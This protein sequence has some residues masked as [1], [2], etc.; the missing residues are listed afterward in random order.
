MTTYDAGEK[1]N[2]KPMSVDEMCATIAEATAALAER[3]A[4]IA[5]LRQVVIDL[6]L[7]GWNFG[8]DSDHEKLKAADTLIHH[9]LGALWLV[10][11]DEDELGYGKQRIA[12]DALIRAKQAGY[13]P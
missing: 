5:R 7:R 13:E 8:P 10:V 6:K 9:L 11:T 1:I 2:M 3:D 4:E 12:H